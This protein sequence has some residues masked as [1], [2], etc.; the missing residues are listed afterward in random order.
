MGHVC[1]LLL[2]GDIHAITAANNLCAAAID[3]RIFH[4]NTQSDEALYRRYLY[5]F[6]CTLVA[7]CQGVCSQ[8]AC[9]CRSSAHMAYLMIRSRC[10][11]AANAK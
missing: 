10:A 9:V 7:T 4:E 5:M 3:T 1:L 8:H 6:M 2:P 11:L